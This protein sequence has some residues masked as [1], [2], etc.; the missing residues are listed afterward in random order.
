MTIFNTDRLLDN[1]LRIGCAI[2]AGILPFSIFVFGAAWPFDRKSDKLSA[3]GVP[4]GSIIGIVWFILIILWSLCGVLAC[5]RFDSDSLALFL[6][7]SI[8]TLLFSVIWLKVH[9]DLRDRSSAAQIL[10]VSLLFA[11]LTHITAVKANADDVIVSTFVSL[12]MTPLV[13]WLGAATMFNYI[14]INK[15]QLG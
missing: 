14:S 9:N 7:F 8:L 13:V 12:G 10:L 3:I 11:T 2:L 15:I 5:F 4:A 1:G 6:P